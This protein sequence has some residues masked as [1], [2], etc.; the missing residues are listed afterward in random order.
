MLCCALAHLDVALTL[1]LLQRMPHGFQRVAVA[2]N[3]KLCVD[4]RGTPETYA[5]YRCHNM[6]GSAATPCFEAAVG[7]VPAATAM[8]GTCIPA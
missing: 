8:P 1:V 3:L 6:A 5:P 4:H 2:Q 7:Q